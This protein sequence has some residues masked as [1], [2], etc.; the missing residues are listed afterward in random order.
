L[1]TEEYRPFF[2]AYYHPYWDHLHN[3]FFRFDKKKYKEI[4]KLYKLMGKWNLYIM[5]KRR[6]KNILA[7]NFVYSSFFISSKLSEILFNISPKL[8]KIIMERLKKFSYQFKFRK[9]TENKKL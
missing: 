9:G 1:F 2:M 5:T 4:D 7:I 8:E 6:F 3:N